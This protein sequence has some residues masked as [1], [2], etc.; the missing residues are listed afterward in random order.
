VVTTTLSA[1]GIMEAAASG[2]VT[3]AADREGGYIFPGFLPGFDAAAALAKLIDLL[4]RSDQSLEHLRSRLPDMPILHTEI[5][6]PFEQKGLIM[7]TLMEQLTEEEAELVLIDGIKVLSE[8][9]WVLVV[10]DPEWPMTH[11][12]T[13]GGDMAASTRLALAYGDRLHDML[14]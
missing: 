9:G 4:G 12:W 14:S 6:T 11:I 2:G 8:E 7:R 1:S 5:E 3:F 10:P 13:E